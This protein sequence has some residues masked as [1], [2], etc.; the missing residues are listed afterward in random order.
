MSDTITYPF[1]IRP[2]VTAYVY[3]PPNLTAKE[4]HRLAQY[5]LSLAFE[6][7]PQEQKGE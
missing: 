7:A 6:D 1:A 5:V 2:G 3:L 4:A